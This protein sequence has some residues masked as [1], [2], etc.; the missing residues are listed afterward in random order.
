MKVSV[1]Y[2]AIDTHK[3]TTTLIHVVFIFFWHNPYLQ[4]VVM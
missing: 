3:F 2:F 4:I 1:W